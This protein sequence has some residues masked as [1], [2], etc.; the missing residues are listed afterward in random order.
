M[1]SSSIYYFSSF[2]S[3]NKNDCRFQ[4]IVLLKHTHS[5]KS[6]VVFSPKSTESKQVRLLLQSEELTMQLKLG[7]KICIKSG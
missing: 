2:M 3:V 6:S 4:L 1:E 5:L 7:G